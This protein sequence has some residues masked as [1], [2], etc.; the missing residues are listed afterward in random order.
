MAL[1]VQQIFEGLG[2]GAIYAS[3]ALALAIIF[4]STGVVNFAQGE[5]A[6]LGTYVVWQFND[7][8]LAIWAAIAVGVVLSFFGGAL[9]ERA[10]IRPVEGAKPLTIV[11]VTFGIFLVLNGLVVWIWSP[12]AKQFPAPL[13]SGGTE[14]GG[15]SI[16]TDSL[17]LLGILVVEVV[18]IWAY[19]RFTKLGMGMRA[20]ALQ[21]TE[22]RLVGMRVGLMLMAGWGLSAAIGTL[23]GSLVANR[24]FLTPSL[25]VN[26]LVYAF[27]G[28]A[29]G[30]FDSPA[31]AVIGGL[32]VGVC[33]SLTITYVDVV[34]NQLRLLVPLALIVVVLLVRP[35]GLFGSTQVSRA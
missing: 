24:L 10:I 19:F 34:G 11:I 30:G 35:Q 7:D 9:I 21:P 32:A 27:A 20:A 14:I 8:G 2:L 15:V 12:I 3:L 18:A 33:E 16:R 1:F 29:L 4:R 28:A 25:M 17:F 26:L 6:L 5:M 13:P 22:S 31:G 23:A